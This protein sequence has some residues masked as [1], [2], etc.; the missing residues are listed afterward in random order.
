MI[1]HLASKDC[2]GCTACA[3]VCPHGA[4]TMQP[5]ALGFLYPIINDSKCIDC[6]LCERVCA[7]N[8]SYDVSSNFKEPLVFAARHKNIKEVNA[9]Q[10]GA[11]FVALSDYILEQ[12]GVVYGVG[13]GDHFKAIH[14][15]AINKVQRDEFRGSKYVQSDLTGIFIQIREDLKSGLK[16]MFSGTPCQT[17][18]LSSF[19]GK[20]FREN[21]YLMDIVCHGVPAP[22]V[23]ND[24]LTYLESKENMKITRA[25][26]RDKKLKGWRSHIESFCFND[27]KIY[28]DTYTFA[29]YIHLTLRHSC[30]NC[31]YTNLQRPSDIS[32]A[33]FW[34][35]EKTQAA[36]LGEDNKGCSLMLVNTEKGKVWYESVKEN[37]YSIPV[38][39]LDC[40]QPN[41]QAPSVL[42]PKR[43]E[44]EKDYINLG[45]VKTLKKYNLI[46]WKLD[47]R[48][49]ISGIKNAIPRPI[50][51]FAKKLL[52][53]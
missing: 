4:I 21:L 52:G 39:T 44:F 25:D 2:C 26:F 13:Y 41:L 31:P 36:E 5:D 8:D 24:Y 1:K 10:S 51:T 15:R 22:L 12:G 28:A 23:W 16:V 33:D 14:K 11:A 53:R 43:D 32:V 47:L 7:F 49:I 48:K 19:I 20:R 46:G 27:K 18:G 3:S 42:H 34:G 17:A 35:V 40:M 6:G 38:S 37:V 50:V 45:L 29:F 30:G 9:S